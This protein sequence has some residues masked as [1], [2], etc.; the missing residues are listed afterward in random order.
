MKIKSIEV[1]NLRFEYPNAH[2]FAYAGG[3]CTARVTSI[4]QVKTDDG[5]VGIGAAY[6]HPALVY[7]IAKTQMEPHLVGRDASD[8][9]GLWNL[10]YGLTRW[11]GRKGAAISAIGAIETALWDLRG[12]A[13]GKPI[14]KLLGGDKNSCPAYASAL[15][16]KTQN[17]HEELASEAQ[18]HLATGFRR[19]KMR[20]ARGEEADLAAVRAVRNAIGDRADLIVDASM[21][22]DVPTARRM[23]EVLK[24]CN[25]FWFEEPFTPED[26]DSYCALRGTIDVPLAAGENEFG[27]QGFNE[28]IHR[29]AV[30]IVQPDASR[31]GGIGETFRVGQMAAQ[32]GLRVATH[33]WS[34]VVAVV[35]NA[36]VIAALPNGITVEVDRTGNPFIE[37]LLQEPLTIKDGELQL[38]DSPGLGIELNP[39]TLEKYR[40]SDPLI[41]PDGNYSD[42]VFG[43]KYHHVPGPYRV[44]EA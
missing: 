9:E 39:E 1:F 34:D 43:A 13:Q 5:Q 6:S 3:V 28:V 42:M 14:W 11:Y 40:M 25:V 19:M 15:L 12:K 22:L 23:A 31:C 17:E 29:G 21:R 36:H 30:D 38:G 33:T 20:L 41:V 8:V 27:V 16:W 44:S 35:A 24:E 18:S 4:I 7:L 37:E 26:L 10:M 2:G 32:N